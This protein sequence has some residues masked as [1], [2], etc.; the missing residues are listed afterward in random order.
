MLLKE[1]LST[2]FSVFRMTQPG[3]EPRFPGPLANLLILFLKIKIHDIYSHETFTWMLENIQRFILLCT[4]LIL[5]KHYI[6]IL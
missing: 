4:L 5:E 2:I 1:K 6:A 3:I